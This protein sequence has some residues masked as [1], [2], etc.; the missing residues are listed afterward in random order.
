MR[1]YSLTIKNRPT[2]VAVAVGIVGA[3]VL[4][5]FVGFAL[6]AALTVA[7]A[8]LGAGFAAYRWLHGTRDD[9]P[10][11]R[12]AGLDP[13]L[14]IQPRPRPLAGPTERSDG[15]SGDEPPTA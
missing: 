7:G 14:E 4:I 6:L 1:T 11:A 9:L 8:V 13:S 2:A 10:Q 12:S 3:G 15:A 5:V